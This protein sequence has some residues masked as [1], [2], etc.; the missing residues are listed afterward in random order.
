MVYRESRTGLAIHF[1]QKVE[2]LRMDVFDKVE[3]KLGSFA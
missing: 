1:L 2:T 3:F